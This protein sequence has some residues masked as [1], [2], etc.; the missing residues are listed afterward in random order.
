[1]E[2]LMNFWYIV[3]A[4]IALAVVIGVSIYKFAGL[5]T[6]D[7]ISKVKEWLLYAVT[8]V[9]SELG[10]NT[11]KLKLRTVYDMFI[12]RFPLVAKIISFETFSLWVDEAL[13]EMREMLENNL[14]INMIV[15]TEKLSR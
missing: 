9:E 4:V 11:G 6:K 14:K 1:M 15:N 7:Q 5:P 10:G 2:F 12:T 13:E 8:V 3:V